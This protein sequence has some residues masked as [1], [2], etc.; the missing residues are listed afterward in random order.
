VTRKENQPL[1]I[2]VFVQVE[3]T[4]GAWCVSFARSQCLR[5][6]VTLFLDGFVFRLLPIM[7]L[8]LQQHLVYSLAGS[9]RRAVA[10]VPSVSSNKPNSGERV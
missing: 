1:L 10:G 8:H 7:L 9:L 5:R 2:E 4:A 3:R 6:R